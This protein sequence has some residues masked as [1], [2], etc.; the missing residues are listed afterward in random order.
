[1]EDIEVRI[2][3]SGEIYVKIEG[4]TEQRIE[5]Y[6]RFLEETFG[7]AT[8][9]EIIRRPDWDQ[10]AERAAENSGENEIELDHY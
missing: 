6:H 4:A 5:S 2:S 7:P 1:M 8:A 10:P 3:K 9:K